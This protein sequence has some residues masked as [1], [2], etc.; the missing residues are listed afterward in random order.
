M[1]SDLLASEYQAFRESLERVWSLDATDA[2]FTSLENWLTLR[3]TRSPTG[4]LAVEGELADQ[5]GADI[6]NRVIFTL[7]VDLA[8]ADLQPMI[9]AVRGI[10]ENFPV[11]GEPAHSR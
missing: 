8:I 7:R 10:E 2:E 3:I 6:G 9:R 4:S 1:D 5:P 11:L